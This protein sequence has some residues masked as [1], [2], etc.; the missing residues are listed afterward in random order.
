MS[1]ENPGGRYIHFGVREHAMGAL[2]NAIAA[3][4]GLR[5]FCSTFFVF[6]DYLRP[7]V[8]M[9]ALMQLPVV[10]VM[11]HDSIGVGEDGPTHQPVEQLAAFRAMPG[12]VVS[13]PGDANETSQAWAEALRRSGSTMIVLSRQA[14]PVI[15]HDRV[16][17]GATVVRDGHDAIIIGT[18]TEVAIA[19]E[20]ATLLQR[21]G[22]S[23]RVVSLPS[24]ERFRALDE[25]RRIEVVS[26]DLSTVAVEA[27]SSQGW[28]EFADAVVG[29]DRFGASAPADVVY[30]QLGLTAEA[31]AERVHHLLDGGGR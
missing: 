13:R 31:V 7:A 1:A 9:S 10:W 25:H 12:L 14:M 30:R 19:V 6:S 28:L 15:P 5:P 24:W 2:S 26:S 29:L 23:A 16:D 3:H 18:G 11:T 22:V 27:G 8:R 17:N 21:D 20:A 4:G